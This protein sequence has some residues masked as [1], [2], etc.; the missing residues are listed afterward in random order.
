M[1]T[2]TAAF[3]LLPLALL[4]VLMWRRRSLLAFQLLLDVG[5]LLIPVLPLLQGHHL[6]PGVPAAQAWGA[7]RTVGGSPEF[8]DF[9]LQFSVWWDEVRRLAAHGEPPFIS[10]RIGGG[11]ALL[12]HG[13][14]AVL[15]P[16][17]LP[18]WLLGPER[19]A[20]V[21]GTWKLELTAL[22][23]FLLLR[24][25]R[26][27]PAAAATGALALSF[28][29]LPTAWLL[30]PMTWFIAALP[31]A[32][33][34]LIGSLRGRRREAAGLALLL[35]VMGGSSLNPETAGFFWLGVLGGGAVLAWGKWRRLFRLAVPFAVAVLVA[36][37][38]ALPVLAAI[39]DS[40]KLTIASDHA[41]PTPW[42]TWELRGRMLAWF[43]APWR[44]GHPADGSWIWPFPWTAVVCWVGLL[45]LTLL[46]V[47]GPRRRLRRHALAWLV[48][49]STAFVLYLQ[50][51]P[52][53]RLLGMVPGLRLMIWV[54]AAFLMAFGL[55]CLAAL[56]ADSWLRRPR[57]TRLLVAALVASGASLGAVVSA[58]PSF[59]TLLACLLA[60]VPLAAAAALWRSAQ[61]RSWIL[62]VLVLVEGCAV[63]MS[64]VPSH[65]L[66]VA[67][68]RPPLLQRLVELAGEERV[69][70]LGSALPANLAARAGLSDV[71]AFDPLRAAALATL[72]RAL[73]CQGEDPPGP[74]T[75]PLAGLGGSWG[76]GWLATPADGVPEAFATGW[77]EVL[78]TQDGRIYRNTRALPPLRLATA[79]VCLPPDA[80]ETIDYS[81]T[82][83]AGEPL[84]LGGTGKI[85]VTER[86]PWRWRAEVEAHGRVL[87]V[88]HVPRSPGWRATVDGREAVIEEVNL[89]AMGVLLGEGR[90]QVCWLYF[91]PLLGLG[92][93]LSLAGLVLAGVL[94]L[95]RRSFGPFRG[96]P[97]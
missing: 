96:S 10:D 31:W 46:A 43:L 57:P 50:L 55:C 81:T 20:D 77:V 88:L 94:G 66:A 91:P 51:P 54:R 68:P 15:F 26:L 44:D 35:G 28:T 64:A 58:P 93:A 86:R 1:D 13:Q 32:W 2:A 62:P 37:A 49:V 47:A 53:A 74:V 25:L 34:L 30:S 63:S 14:S 92:G 5:L 87:A 29:L 79:A 21:L 23:A 9:P 97:R 38:G 73:G 70:G 67:G 7:P 41:Y 89:G 82:V 4:H 8:T 22:G 72:H 69:L 48:V 52:L 59:R 78:R 95:R 27:R 56:A 33:F 85:S 84:E 16:L 60:G 40:P 71:R 42:L 17:Q 76:V 11:A 45:V 24:R 83:L 12:A 3:I 65:D 80:V 90:H 39:G 18:V 19:G 61:A 75:R 6:G 36:A